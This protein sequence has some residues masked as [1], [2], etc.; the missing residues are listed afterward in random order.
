M[1]K[2]WK[3]PIVQVQLFVLQEYC[4]SGCYEAITNAPNWKQSYG[5]II[6]RPYS[7]QYIDVNGNGSYDSGE[8]FNVNTGI[9]VTGIAT[10]GPNTVH[11]FGRYETGFLGIPT[12]EYQSP[13]TGTPR[14][15]TANDFHQ[16]NSFTIKI[17]NNTAYYLPAGTNAS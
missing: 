7:Y 8:M 3:L 6:N 2:S 13:P 11:V 12:S 10:S 5:I 17:V 16:T 4:D 15:T 1:K 9:S 14:Y